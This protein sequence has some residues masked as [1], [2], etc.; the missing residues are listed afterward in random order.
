MSLP[1]K[2]ALGFVCLWFLV[3]GIG[4]FVAT[5]FFVHIVPPYIPQPRAVVYLSGACELLGAIGILLP[6]TRRLAGIGLI[7]LTVCVTP[8]NVHMWLH[9]EQFPE[10]PAALFGPRLVLQVL[11]LALILWCTQPRTGGA[12]RGGAG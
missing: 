6:G 3:G 7:A 2:L 4:H 11:L 8:A 9:P 5:D 12:G 1:R 10:F